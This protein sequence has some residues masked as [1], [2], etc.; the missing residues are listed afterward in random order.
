MISP[1]NVELPHWGFTP[2]LSYTK[3]H[4]FQHL[5]EKKTKTKWIYLLYPGHS[6]KAT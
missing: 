6:E 2:V 5:L 1:S 3:A 4:S